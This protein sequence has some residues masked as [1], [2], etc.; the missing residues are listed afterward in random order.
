MSRRMEAPVGFECPYRHACPHLDHLSTTWT[1]EVYQEVFKL[2]EQYHDMEQRYQQRIA[3]L[4]ETLRERDAKIAQLRVQ[5]QKQFKAKN[6]RPPPA[7]RGQSKKRGAPKGHRPWRR[8]EPDH[9]DE[10]I[11]VPAPQTCPRCNCVG[12]VSSTELY[13][14]IQEDIV[15]VPRTR[16][17]RFVHSQSYCP[18]CRRLV[19]QP[20]EGELPGCR[21]GPVTRAVATHLRYNLQIPYRKVQ[22]I[23]GHLFGMR[24]VPASVMGF[25]R[26]ATT[27]GRPL[28]EELQAQLKSSEVVYADETSW[29][30]D[31]QNHYIWFGGNQDLAVY[32]ITDNRSA[33]SAVQLP[34]DDFDGILV[35]D[36]Y[37]AYNAVNASHRQTCWSHVAV[38]AKE[39]LK[40]IE[41]TTPPISVPQSVAFCKKLKRFASRLCG[42]GGQ[43]RDK[44]LTRPKARAMIPSLQRQLKRFASRPMD[45]GP[46]ETLRDRLMNKDY[47]KLF[48]FLK[49]AGVEPTNNH[50]ERSLRFLVIMRKICFGTRSE[51]HVRYQKPAV[52]CLPTLLDSQTH[53]TIPTSLAIGAQ[54]LNC[55]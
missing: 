8:R 38:R 34:G 36:A 17:T 44:K 6:K 39:I 18:Q 11:E 25:D 10:N 2:N 5:H 26:K 24:L 50:A 3:E 31:G 16:V 19:Y 12:L 9:V 4:E 40:Q 21:I 42:L 28:Y 27:L 47:D 13:Q 41:L 1:M 14:H 29:R 45:Y 35:T 15:L 49:I 55:Y 30:L 32:K 51:E 46:A 37:A 54:R 48:T 20:T 7:L 23:L 52:P 43:L 33:D 53:H 22:H